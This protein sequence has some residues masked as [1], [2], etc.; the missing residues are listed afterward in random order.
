MRLEK[1]LKAANVV[2]STEVLK[3]LFG[4]A[5]YG[6]SLEPEI[7]GAALGSLTERR[8]GQGAAECPAVQSRDSVVPLTGVQ[9]ST[10]LLT[11]PLGRPGLQQESRHV[12]AC[13]HDTDRRP[14]NEE[15]SD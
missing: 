12:S 14:R 2:P 7:W 13:A 15:G 8:E 4:Q 1:Y 3:S 11:Q 6:D 9:T 5:P 10:L